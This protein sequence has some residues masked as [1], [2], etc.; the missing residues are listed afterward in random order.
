VAVADFDGDGFSDIFVANDNERNFLFH[1]V[2]G[3]KF[4]ET[5]IQAGVAY[6]EDGVAASSM[7][8][9][10]RDLDDD[11]RPDL[12]LTA[13]AGEVFSVRMNSGRG[14]FDDYTFQSGLGLSA[15]VMSG[16]SVGAYDFDNDGRKDVFITNS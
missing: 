7:G 9:D 5:G 6:T 16:W 10:F 1:N 2:G 14:L 4:E 13:L 12:V 15:N 8:V 11:G 3:R